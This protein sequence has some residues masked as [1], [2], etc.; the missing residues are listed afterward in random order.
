[1]VATIEVT[2]S[3]SDVPA[4]T[5]VK[6]IT[7]WLTPHQVAMLTAP[8]TSHFDPSPNKAKPTAIN[9]NDFQTATPTG[10]L[11]SAPIAASAEA[12]CAANSSR[13]SLLSRLAKRMQIRMYPTSTENKITPSRRLIKPSRASAHPNTET[14]IISG[15]SKRINW[16]ETTSGEI[17]AE[18]PRINNTLKMLLPTTLPTATSAAP[19]NA[20]WMLT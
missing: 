11:S 10:T 12:Y 1:M 2:T 6:P 7:N 20:A 18:M 17:I 3:G 9:S 4:A 8:S 5:I 15:T 16:L 19:A 13:T 14:A